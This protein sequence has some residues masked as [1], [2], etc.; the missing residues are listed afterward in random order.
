[1]LQ[2]NSIFFSYVNVNMHSYA[3]NM[4]RLL[5]CM[6]KKVSAFSLQILDLIMT[7]HVFSNFSFLSIV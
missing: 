4:H 7:V 1:M 3:E 5:N 2:N 6:P